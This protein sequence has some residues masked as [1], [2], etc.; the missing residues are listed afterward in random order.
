LKAPIIK[1]AAIFL[2]AGSRFGRPRKRIDWA[3]MMAVAGVAIALWLLLA[4]R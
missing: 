3:L 1:R 4:G 2:L